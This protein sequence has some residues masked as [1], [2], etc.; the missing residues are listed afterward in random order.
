M[1]RV[2]TTVQSK[3]SV[4]TIEAITEVVTGGAGNDPTP[5][6]G[7]YR[8]GPKLEH[9]FRALNIELTIG[10]SSRVPSVRDALDRENELSDRRGRLI[11]VVEALADPREFI[12]EPEKLDAVVDYLNKRLTSDGYEIRRIGDRNRVVSVAGATV[13]TAALQQQAAELQLDSVQA[14]F[15]RAVE[16]ADTDPA[17]AITSACSTVESVCK[18]ILDELQ[19]D[20]PKKQDIKSLVNEVASHLNLAPSRTDLPKNVE[21]DLKQ[22]LSGLFSVVGGLGALRTHAGDAHGRGRMSVPVDERIARLAIN[23]AST[24]SMFYIETWQRKAK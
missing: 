21:Q 14:D 10:A 18:C 15:E 17:G 22:I 19:C 20:H 16:Q 8:S 1:A 4:Q 9:F 24:L 11:D 23:A 6:I 2:N 3:L 7:H 5:P 13:A 12:D